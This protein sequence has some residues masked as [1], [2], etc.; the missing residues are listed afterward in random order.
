M[1]LEVYMMINFV[2]VKIYDLLICVCNLFVVLINNIIQWFL[3]FNMIVGLIT[4]YYT[5]V[6]Q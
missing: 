5:R 3:T 4:V 6:K 2:V 1:L